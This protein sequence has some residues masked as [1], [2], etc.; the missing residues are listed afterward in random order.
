MAA[1]IRLEIEDV[2]SD[3]ETLVGPFQLSRVSEAVKAPKVNF[4]TDNKLNLLAVKQSFC[5]LVFVD[6]TRHLSR[7]GT[8][9]GLRG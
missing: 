3:P 1:H 9:I 2:W 8:R 6:V 4:K 7:H 5:I